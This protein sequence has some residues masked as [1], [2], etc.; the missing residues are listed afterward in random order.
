ML[1]SSSTL[2]NSSS[3][4]KFTCR[5]EISTIVHNLAGRISRSGNVGTG[6]GFLLGT[7][8]L[9]GPDLAPPLWWGLWL[10]VGKGTTFGL[11]AYRLEVGFVS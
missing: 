1:S 2:S 9:S 4:G 3:F 10:H 11:G 6:P 8:E 7:F 5:C